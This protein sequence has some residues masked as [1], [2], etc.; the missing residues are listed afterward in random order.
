MNLIKILL[1]V[2][3]IKKEIRKVLKYLK[4]VEFE[5][6]V[7]KKKIDLL[8]ENS[9]PPIFTK[10]S[11]SVLDE[12]VQLIEAFLKGLEKIGTSEKNVAN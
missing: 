11:Y 6:E 8:E 7:V 2:N 12:R 9:H 1:S 5:I 10:K 3:T 4:A